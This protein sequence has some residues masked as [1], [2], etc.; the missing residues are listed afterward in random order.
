MS[1][2]GAGKVIFGLL[3]TASDVTDIVGTSPVKVFPIVAPQGIQPPYVTYFKV[4]SD[5]QNSKD[6]QPVD[7]IRMQIDCY[8]LEYP[9]LEDL[10]SAVDAA[11][12]LYSGTTNGVVVDEIRFETENDTVEEQEDFYRL[13]A[14][15][16]QRV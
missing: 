12:N 9:V 7:H 3:S 15:W 6:G 8:A 5:P 2:T 4:S 10:H 1:R 16:Q 13:S 11:L 14:E